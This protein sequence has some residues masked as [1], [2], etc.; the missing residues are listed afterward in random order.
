MKASNEVSNM[1]GV[2][3]AAVVMATPTNLKLLKDMGLLTKEMQAVTQNDL[4]IAVDGRTAATVEGAVARIESLLT[5]E[6]PRGSSKSAPKTLEAALNEMSDANFVAISVPGE[7]AGPEALTALRNGLNVFLFSSNVPLEKEIELKALAKRKGLLMMGPDCGTAI[8]N[9]K[10]LGFGN[11]VSRGAVGIISASGTGL[12]QVSTLLDAE[13]AGVSQAIG[14]GSRDLWEDVGG[15]TMIEGLRRLLGDRD[16]RIV[17]LVSKPPDAK[18]SDLVFKRASKGGKPVVVSFLGGDP[19][20]VRKRGLVPAETL[21]DAAG[22]A[23]DLLNNREPAPRTFSLERA[24]VLEGARGEWSHL[25][26]DQKYIRGLYSGGTLC[27]E[28]QVI[29]AP[30]VGAVFSNT[31]LRP[32]YQL[33]DPDKSREHTC[34]DLGSEEYVMGRPH[35]MIDYTLRKRRLVGEARDLETAVIILD[36][37]LGYGSNSDPAAELIPTIRQAKLIAEKAGGSLSIVASV[38]GTRND[39][40]GLGGQVK[41]LQDNGVAVMPSNAQAVRFAALVAS[42][43]EVEGNIFAS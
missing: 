15:S 39:P 19:N 7:F 41:R 11:V 1:K 3:Q 32:E 34:V 24:R 42:R 21:E 28:A 5:P 27:Y 29:L 20:A 14:T 13:G 33:A 35:P 36:V 2:R 16:T 43:G 40:Q 8:I 37:V 23:I 26:P 38:I 31:P 9:G 6:G 18:T 17:V 4:V 22:L 25:S 12:Q 10:V 30:L